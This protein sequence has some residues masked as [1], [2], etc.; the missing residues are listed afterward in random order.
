ML[1]PTDTV[2]LVTGAVKGIGRA[3][4]MDLAHEGA[5]VI[6]NYRQDEE[7]AKETIRLIEAAGGRAALAKADIADEDSVRGLFKEI[8]ETYGRLDVL[9]ANAGVSRDRHL[10]TMGVDR[11]REVLDVNMV[12]TFLTC[13]EAVRLMEHRRSGSIV[14]I[15]SA[16]GIHGGLPGQTNYAASKGGIIAFSKTL[17][18]EVSRRGIRVNTVAPGFVETE[19]TN[20]LPAARRKEYSSRI[21]LGRM[22][23]PEEVAYLVSFLAS[24][25]GSYITGSVLEVHGGGFEYG[26]IIH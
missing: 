8:R 4:A 25:R 7:A 13:R 12:G 15:S 3:V 21:G 17:A 1:F 2:A 22:A 16:V 20:A 23:R 6:V 26:A 5:E 24:S 11:F 19:M 18:N 14:T 10:I 9:V